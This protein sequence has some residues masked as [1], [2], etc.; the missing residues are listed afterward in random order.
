MFAQ[1]GSFLFI[2]QHLAGFDNVQVGKIKNPRIHPINRVSGFT[3]RFDGRQ[4]LHSPDKLAVRSWIIGAPSAA[5]A[6]FTPLQVRTPEISYR[7]ITRWERP[8]SFGHA[9]ARI[10]HSGVVV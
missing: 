6:A 8:S 7:R 4:P 2:Q 1:L 3:I 5:E 10:H 9:Y